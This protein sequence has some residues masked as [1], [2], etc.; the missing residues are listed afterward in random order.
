MPPKL[1]IRQPTA[2]Q[3]REQTRRREDAEDA[4]DAVKLAEFERQNDRLKLKLKLKAAQTE[5]S[6]LN[7]ELRGVPQP[8]VRSERLNDR[9]DRRSVPAPVPDRPD[10]PENMILT[11]TGKNKVIGKIRSYHFS[12]NDYALSRDSTLTIAQKI[13]GVAHSHKNLKNRQMKLDFKSAGGI[14]NGLTDLIVSDAKSNFTIEAIVGM[15]TRLME[16]KI[17]STSGGEWLVIGLQLI[18]HL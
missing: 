13:Y 7:D 9:S 16:D 6:R 14:G 11:D 15:L 2:A 8:A 12:I 5:N 3:R 10:R 17:A 4:A 18:G 1:V